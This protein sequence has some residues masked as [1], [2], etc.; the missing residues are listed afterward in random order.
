MNR[1]VIVVAVLLSMGS[2]GA[3]AL[4]A[5]AVPYEPLLAKLKASGGHVSHVV[6]IAAPGALT[7]L[8]SGKR[9]KFVLDS[10]S[11][12]T[13]APLPVDEPNNEYV[14]PILAGGDRVLTAGDVTV[15]HL[16]GN[17]V[18]VVLD[19]DSKSYCPT[20]RSLDH[21]A[22]VLETLGVPR[23]VI[24]RQDRRPQCITH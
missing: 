6:R 23:R 16:N 20:L 9:Y 10:A 3:P 13:V 1:L 15:E 4:F 17:I 11:A 24:S 2:C 8:Q 22:R 5:S 14:H 7:G 18:H 12:L 19:Q 21:A